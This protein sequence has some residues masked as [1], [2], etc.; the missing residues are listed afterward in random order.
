MPAQRIRAGHKNPLLVPGVHRF[1]RSAMYRKRG[2]KYKKN[3]TSSSK[4]TAKKPVYVEKP[5]G[6][7]LNGEKRQVQVKKS[8]RYHPTAVGKVRRVVQR[9]GIVRRTRIRGSL[10]PGTVLILLAGRHAGKRVI[11]L[12]QLESGLLLVT[13]PFKLN[14]V[15]LRR[16]NQQYVIATSTRLD[17]TEVKVPD[18]LN[19]AYFRRDKA[20]LR[21]Q[22]QQQEGEIFASAKTGYSLSDTRKKDQGELDKQIL[23]V[24]KSSPDKKLLMKYLSSSFALRS[25]QYPHKMIF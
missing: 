11:L 10:K 18:T 1:G 17:L 25:G 8:K 24:I 20:A 14:G 22:R 6:G 4:A 23:S 16:I 21:K 15:P 19:D 9:P 12:G 5:V 7:A 3:L 13:G 2:M